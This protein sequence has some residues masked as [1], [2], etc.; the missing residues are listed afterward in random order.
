MAT[1]PM[2]VQQNPAL[3]R[4]LAL[5]QALAARQ[6]P[7]R[8]WSSGLANGVN[9]IVGAM[10]TRKAED[11]IEA[12]KKAQME[13][14]ARALSAAEPWRNPD[15]APM[16]AD[17]MRP[18]MAPQAPGGGRYMAPGEV[19][20]GTGGIDAFASVLAGNEALAPVAAQ[21]QLSR[22]LGNEQA[23]AAAAAKEAEALRD[24]P[25]TRTIER[26]DEK[27]T[28]E[29]DRSTRTWRDLATAPRKEPYAPSIG[30]DVLLPIAR[31]MAR[32]EALTPAEQKTVDTFNK[33]PQ[34]ILAALGLGVPNVD[35]APAPEAKRPALPPRDQLV[36]GQSYTLPDGQP[37]VW[38]G[39][40]F[41][42]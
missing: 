40:G 26:G 1:I 14:L 5:A 8:D 27:I 4:R 7:V 23:R 42:R 38:D 16:A 20:R 35:D 19:A 36:K 24:A 11:A 13:T 6:Q 29:W 39:E 9:S 21:V 32:G 10:Q 31:K 28:Q 25:K 17:P 2:I 12:D 15:T 3:Q 30:R 33:N 37:A 18:D 34:D 22:M 41:V